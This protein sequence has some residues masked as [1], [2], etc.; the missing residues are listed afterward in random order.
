MKK[1]VFLLVAA[2]ISTTISAQLV[3]STTVVK[4]KKAKSD[5]GMF[6]ELGLGTYGS[7]WDNDG[8]ALDLGI[9]YRK[10]FSEYIAWDIFKVKAMS[11]LSNFS[12]SLAIQGLTAIRG[13][14]PVLFGNVTSFG[15]FG[16]GYGYMPHEYIE[17]GG[18][19]Y[20]IQAGLN[21]TPSI[22]ISLAYTNQKIKE[23]DWSANVSF[24]GAKVG[25][26]F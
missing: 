16:L 12:E 23:D 20:E 11:E 3:T 10:S 9:G 7:D 8:V 14:S 5:S 22:S 4:E 2:F 25:F 24:I 15:S 6:M 17:A 13:T 26:R 21:V 18:F 1:V 19:V